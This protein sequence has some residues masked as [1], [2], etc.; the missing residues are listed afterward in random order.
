MSMLDTMT[1]MPL[2]PAARNTIRRDAQRART[3]R[4]ELDAILDEASAQH[5][6]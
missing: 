5:Y 4:S 6:R 1:R 3:D 2:S